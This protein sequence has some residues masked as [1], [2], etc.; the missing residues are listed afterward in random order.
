MELYKEPNGKKFIYA[1]TYT[2]VLGITLYTYGQDLLK[3]INTPKKIVTIGDLVIFYAITCL[4]AFKL[5][6]TKRKQ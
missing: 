1:L 6:Y 2:I 4:V 3:L 5:A